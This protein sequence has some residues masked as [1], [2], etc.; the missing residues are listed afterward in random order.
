[1]VVVSLCGPAVFGDEAFDYVRYLVG[2][3]ADLGH[4]DAQQ[5]R[6]LLAD[7]T[8]DVPT[9][10]TWEDPEYGPEVLSALQTG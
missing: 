9:F 5:M 7:Q 10:T 4:G 1:M 6:P 2:R 3:A 8:A